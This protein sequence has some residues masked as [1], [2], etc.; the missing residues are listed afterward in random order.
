M[1]RSECEEGLG[2]NI[3]AWHRRTRVS[4]PE[5]WSQEA[6]DADELSISGTRRYAARSRPGRSVGPP[7]NFQCIYATEMWISGACVPVGVVFLSFF[8]PFFLCLHSTTRKNENHISVEKAQLMIR[9]LCRFDLKPNPR[10]HYFLLS[11]P[12]LKKKMSD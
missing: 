11:L 5:C 9:K 2:E 10:F 8:L 12:K 3:C 4:K 1:R 7:I 6:E